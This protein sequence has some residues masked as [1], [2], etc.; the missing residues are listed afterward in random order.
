M[1]LGQA[2]ATL[3]ESGAFDRVRLVVTSDHSW[4]KERDPNFS[5]APDSELR[6]P[7]VVKH[8]Y[9]R[10]GRMSDERVEVMELPV[11]DDAP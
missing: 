8:P 10:E 7:L 1:V 2:V 5:S 4:T 6:V 11:W 3:R 9:Q